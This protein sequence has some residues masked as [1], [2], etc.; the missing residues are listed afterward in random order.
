[1]DITIGSSYQN[2]ALTP[3]HKINRALNANPQAPVEKTAPL[4]Q[5]RPAYILDISEEGKQKASELSAEAKQ[6]NSPEEFSSQSE[7]AGNIKEESSI[8]E[9]KTD[10]EVSRLQARDKE[11]RAHEMAHKAVGG[12]HAGSISYTYTTG[13]DGKKYAS[14]GEVPI[15]TSKENTPDATIQKMTQIKRAALAPANPSGADRAI[16]SK[17]AMIAMKARSEKAKDADVSEEILAPL[18]SN[19]NITKP[20]EDN[21]PYS[22]GQVYYA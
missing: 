15:D 14:G 3:I 18:Q 7:K 1:M 8:E 21:N 20:Q 17:A 13:P 16:A 10:L 12:G 5:E 22:T 9:M 11:V 2:N 6:E 4:P 19:Q